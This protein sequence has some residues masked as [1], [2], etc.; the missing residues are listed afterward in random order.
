M[1]DLV[2][3]AL[4]TG[5]KYLKV[6]IL[7]RVLSRGKLAV[8]MYHGLISEPLPFLDWCFVEESEFAEH[9]Q[10]LSDHSFEFLSVQEGW[11]RL[12]LGTLDRPAVAI[13]FDDG[14]E[15]IYTHALPVL[16][17]FQAPASV[18]LVTDLVDSNETLWFCYLID[19]LGKTTASNFSWQGVEYVIGTAKEKA[20]VSNQIQARLKVLHPEE[21]NSELANMLEKL[22]YSR[23]P[24]ES[25]NPFRILNRSQISEMRK[26][27]LFEFGSHTTSHR[28]LTRL[29][30]KAVEAEVTESAEAVRSITGAICREFA[31]PNGQKAD[32]GFDI[33]GQMDEVG[34]RLVMTTQDGY[35]EARTSPYEIRRIGVGPGLDAVTF[36]DRLD[37]LRVMVKSMLSRFS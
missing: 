32:I 18:Y 22:G 8:L 24:I 21:L 17:K 27:G 29:D 7:S 20:V 37:P 28:I 35:N 36:G 33:K 3:Q 15:S 19:A 11:R 12:Q 6:P 23:G 13:T 9:L 4:R 5:Y 34:Y 14:F 30:S 1:S 10:F 2:H 16:K 25:G 26:S 31:Y